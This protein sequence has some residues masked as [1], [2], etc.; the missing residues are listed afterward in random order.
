MLTQFQFHP[1]ITQRNSWLVSFNSLAHTLE[2]LGQSPNQRITETAWRQD[3]LEAG[4]AGA[5]RVA[6]QYAG[7]DRSSDAPPA[8]VA[9]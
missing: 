3:S 4:V 9:Q 1:N 2:Y 8:G 6:K 7:R 5:T